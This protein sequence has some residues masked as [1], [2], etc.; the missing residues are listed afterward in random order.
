VV[1]PHRQGAQHLE[2][3]CPHRPPSEVG[4]RW[5]R[6]TAAQDPHVCAC[7]GGPVRPDLW[8]KDALCT[9]CRNGRAAKEGSGHMVRAALD[10]GAR[11]VEDGDGG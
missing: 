2:S 1:T 4:E 7:C 8:G 11:L 9:V 10:M 5:A 6:V 3:C